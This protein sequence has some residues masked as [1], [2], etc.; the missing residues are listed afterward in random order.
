MEL[1]STIFLIINFLKG[2]CNKSKPIQKINKSYRSKNIIDASEFYN[3]VQNQYNAR[4][5][6]FTFDDGL[7]CQYEIVKP[8]FDEY[9]IKAFFILHHQ[10]QINLAFRAL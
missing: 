6:C 8:V 7:Q 1:H 5:V 4:K 2:Q 10:L 9:K 3:L